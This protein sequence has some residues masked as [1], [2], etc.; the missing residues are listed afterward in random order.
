MYTGKLSLTRINVFPHWVTLLYLIEAIF[1][2]RLTFVE[3]LDAFRPSLFQ[4][5]FI[6]Y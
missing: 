1:R 4:G 5:E 2:V 3:L 6:Y